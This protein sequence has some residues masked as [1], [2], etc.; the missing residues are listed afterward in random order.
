VLTG[1]GDVAVGRAVGPL[2][3]RGF[4][5]AVEAYEIMGLDAARVLP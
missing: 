3:L 2:V 5:G 1:A 4:S